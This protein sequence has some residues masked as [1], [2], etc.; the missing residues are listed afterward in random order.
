MLHEE[1]TQ[2]TY[3]RIVVLCRN[4]LDHKRSQSN[5]FTNIVVMNY[6]VSDPRTKNTHT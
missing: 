3:M 4:M 6:T 5:T 1:K 2:R